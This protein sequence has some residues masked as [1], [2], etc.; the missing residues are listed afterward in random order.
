LPGGG[1]ELLARELAP[2]PI[3]YVKSIQKDS[4]NETLQQ[5]NA[6]ILYS[7]TVNTS[8]TVQRLNKSLQAGSDKTNQS[9]HKRM[10][11]TNNKS[12]KSFLS[13]TPTA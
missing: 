1:G 2:Q 7:Y 10:P 13:L 6:A 11:N 5:P 3:L 9:A 12:Y 8:E 4:M